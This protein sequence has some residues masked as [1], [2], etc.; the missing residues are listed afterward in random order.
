MQRTLHLI[1][2]YTFYSALPC[3]MLHAIA[4]DDSG[5]APYGIE[6]RRAWTGSRVTGSPEPPPPYRTQRVWSELT[7]ENPVE[8]LAMPGT[9][10]MVMLELSG[11]VYAFPD[12]TGAAERRLIFDPVAV[13]AMRQA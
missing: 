8:L 1:A 3:A 5:D 11:R 9:D 7:F 2:A 12:D 10:Q 6:I 4:G 13:R